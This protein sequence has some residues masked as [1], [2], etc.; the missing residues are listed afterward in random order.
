MLL[1]GRSLDL[2]TRILCHAALMVLPAGPF[3]CDHFQCNCRSKARKW[4]AQTIWHLHI[5]SPR[6]GPY[7]AKPNHIWQFGTR[8]QCVLVALIELPRL[9]CRCG[10]TDASSLHRA[11]H[12]TARQSTALWEASQTPMKPRLLNFVP[13]CPTPGTKSLRSADA[14]SSVSPYAATTSDG[15]GAGAAPE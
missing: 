6:F 4:S 11:E 12:D 2:P 1:C 14:R 8:R 7:C 13:S 10:L 5:N 3:L 15:H 9:R